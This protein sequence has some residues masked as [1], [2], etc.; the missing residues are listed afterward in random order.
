MTSHYI[1]LTIVPDAESS[2]QHLL[3]ALYDK[4]HRALAQQRLG[5][6]GVSFPHYSVVP[7][8]LGNTLRLHG[9]AAMLRQ[10]LATDWLKGI[11]D[12]LRMTEI[13]AVPATAVHRLVQ[14]R[15]F[16]TN[17]ERLRRRRMKRKGETAEQAA[18]AIP[19][20]IE[21]KPNLPYV[22]LHSLSSSQPFHLFVELGPPQELPIPGHFNSYGLSPIATIPWF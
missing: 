9:E 21:R 6:I 16:K 22:R 17:V 15:Q 18:C 8:S 4:L 19:I 1:D 14:R 7:K 10:F 2:A 11:R 13:A 3:G 20:T 12:H 5:S